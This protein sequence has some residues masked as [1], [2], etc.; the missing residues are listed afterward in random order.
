MAETLKKRRDAEDRILWIPAAL[1][2]PG[3]SG[4]FPRRANDLFLR[5]SEGRKK[6]PRR[7]AFA[8]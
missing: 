4:L 8:D 3:K 6:H 1:P 7:G 5:A 2:E